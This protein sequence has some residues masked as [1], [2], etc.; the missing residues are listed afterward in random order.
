MYAYMLGAEEKNAQ[1]KNTG[2]TNAQLRNRRTETFP[3]KPDYVVVH[4]SKS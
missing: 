4:Q 3:E 2:E 1:L